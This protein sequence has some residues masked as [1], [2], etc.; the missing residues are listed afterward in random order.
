MRSEEFW[1][2]FATVQPHLGKRAEGFTKIF[3][4]LD[5]FD[6]PVHIVETGCIRKADDWAGDGG[7]TQLFDK[8]AQFYP[9]ST[10]HS[11]DRDEKAAALCRALVS[12]ST[13]IRTGESISVLKAFADIPPE[14]VETIDLLYLDTAE[15]DYENFFPGALHALKELIAIYPLIR[16]ETLIVVNDAP[17]HFSGVFDAQGV[18]Q[19]ASKPR[20]GGNGKL[21][22]EYAHDVGAVCP[23]IGFQSGWT[24]MKSSA[25]SLPGTSK[26]LRAI[27]TESPAGIFAVG[28]GDDHIGKALRERGESGTELEV[29]RAAEFVTKEDDVLVVGTHIGT[30]AIPLAKY[31]GHLTCI[32]ANPETFK[33]LKANIALNNADNITALNFAA[34]DKTETL[35]FYLSTVNSGGSKRKPITDHH[36]YSYDAPETVDVPAHSLDEKLGDKKFALIIMDIEGSEYFAFKG[37]Q[38]ILGHAKALFVEFLPHLINNVAGVT[39]EEF[40][41]P[42][43][44]HF[45]HMRVYS[46]GIEVPKSEFASTL[47]RMFDKEQGD[48]GILFTK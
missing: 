25:R 39:P 2:Y 40:V 43:L 13:H 6:H 1:A 47:R 21:I 26:Y 18:L 23:F 17:P 22:G 45:N 4:H 7:S 12:N 44:P 5:A 36:M 35:K 10:V 8:Y 30:L 48:V 27:I 29:Q 3:Q 32:E 9:G 34:S 16:A 15:V 33:L 46:L 11:I 38:K 19:L 31:C 20:I 14:G 41:A 42:L 37:M 24:R 28:L